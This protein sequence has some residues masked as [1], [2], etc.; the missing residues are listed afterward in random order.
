MSDVN[1]KDTLKLWAFTAFYIPLVFW[2]R[3]RIL[4]VTTKR[5]IIEMPFNRR[6]KN[7]VRSM[8][9]GALSVGAEIG[10]G[11]ITLRLFAEQKHKLTFLFKDF[12]ADFLKRCEAN[13]RFTCNDGDAIA[14]AIKTA[15]E[16]KERQN[17]PV[18]VIAT[19]PEL[20]DE[21]QAHF[22][23]TLSLRAK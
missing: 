17:V 18:S 15:I 7:H 13:V 12:Q 9:F 1:W 14:A 23:L 22:K 20:G 10:P 19:I 6:T 4:E 21:P 11:L 3:P 8:Y 16:T 5:S 2:L